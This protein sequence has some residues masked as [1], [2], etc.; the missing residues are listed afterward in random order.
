MYWPADGKVC[1]LVS[2]VASYLARELTSSVQG[3]HLIFDRY[4][5]FSI[6]GGARAA[7]AQV[8]TPDDAGDTNS[9]EFMLTL[10]SPLPPQS[11]CL[12]VTENKV[13]LISLITDNVCRYV[14]E[15]ISAHQYIIVSGPND[16]PI[17]LTAASPEP[18]DCEVLRN[19]HEEADTIIIHH[20]VESASN[21]GT[22]TIHVRCN[23]T[24]VFV[25][26]CHF[27]HALTIDANILMVP[28][29]Q[30]MKPIDINQ[31]VSEHKNIIPHLL[32]M[33]V[34][35][36]CDT[37][38]KMHG[39]GKIKALTQLKTGNFPPPLGDL[40]VSHEALVKKGTSFIGVCYG[41]P[42]SLT[43]MSGH[44]LRKWKS[45]TKGKGKVFK[46]ETLP[47][48]TEAF[49]LHIRRAHY[50]AAVWRSAAYPDLPDMDP[51]HHGW[52]KDLITR[53][54][55]PMQLPLNTPIAPDVLL[56]LLCCSCDSEES[57]KTKRCSCHNNNTG[58]G[59]FCKCA[60]S[61]RG[62]HNPLTR[63]SADDQDDDQSMDENSGDEGEGEDEDDAQL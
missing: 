56:K 1:D 57:C 5:E 18:E 54:L 22:A 16:V 7:R 60:E 59:T 53:T 62:C 45:I 8:N 10:D 43:S 48:T 9:T 47:P 55:V 32:S 41:N 12:K 30:K 34:I 21:N 39:I 24:D 23:D 15:Y 40:N 2:G 31:T 35:T 6:K 61:D 52:E 4:R 44:R 11:V 20:V 58:C 28:L 49:Q 29:S 36:G 19:T 17:K 25:L 37:V 27:K 14:K 50:Q 3:V 63:S 51:S 33:H 42:S 13:R 38:S 26:L 46:L